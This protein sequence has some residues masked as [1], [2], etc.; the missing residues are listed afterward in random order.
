MEGEEVG[1]EGGGRGI[2][3]LLSP[4]PGAAVSLHPTAAAAAAAHARNSPNRHAVNS[5]TPPPPP[6][7]PSVDKQPNTRQYS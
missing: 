7:S 1:G 2:S 4:T 3:L 5:S 6:L